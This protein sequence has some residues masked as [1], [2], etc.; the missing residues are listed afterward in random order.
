MSIPE[1]YSPEGREPALERGQH[2]ISVFNLYRIGKAFDMSPSERC[3]PTWGARGEIPDSVGPTTTNLKRSL[4]L[5]A[6]G[7]IRRHPHQGIEQV[8]RSQPVWLSGSAVPRR[9]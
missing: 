3:S 5:V 6:V 9:R 7:A 1:P 2:N 8:L 4:L